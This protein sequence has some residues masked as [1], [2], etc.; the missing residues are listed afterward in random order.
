MVRTLGKPLL[1]C[2]NKLDSQDQ[3]TVLQSF[4]QRY[5]QQ[6][7]CTPP[8]IVIL[9][10]VPREI[11]PETS[12]NDG[13][14]DKTIA[15]AEAT[16]G[17]LYTAVQHALDAVDRQTQTSATHQ[18]IDTHWDLWLEPVHQ[19]MTAA[20]QWHEIVAQ[21][22]NDAEQLY[23]SRYLDNPQKYDTFN[24]A[25]AELLTLLEIPGVAK[26]LVRTRQ[27]V[28][29][30]AR[31][32]FG[33]G[34]AALQRDEHQ[35]IPDQEL[36]VLDLAFEQA[37]IHLQSE[38]FEQQQQIDEQLHWWQ[39]MHT[40]FQHN[41]LELTTQF[42]NAAVECQ[43]E[44]APRIE[45]AAKKLYGQLQEQPILL[46]TLRATR[47]STDAAAVVLAVKSGGLAPADLIIA[48]A[49]LS[50]TTLLTESVLGRFMDKIK[51]DLKREQSAHVS[52]HLLAGVL[53][54]RLLELAE[55]LDDEH[56]LLL[57]PEEKPS[58]S[59]VA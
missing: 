8:D 39:A 50:I 31:K 28:T 20:T 37:L 36:D 38:M 17:R 16:R 41:K 15:I 29:W 40:C 58:Q 14:D 6:F 44:F 52:K 45:E 49:M 46:N 30:P 34:R 32:L 43:S 18:F 27:V 26:T 5:Q 56:L 33:F 42:S 7:D 54:K 1:V 57:K 25:L 22:I 55:E 51:A 2:I 12:S 13:A 3:D 23:I 35:T 19:E 9:P 53:K 47:V 24:R 10:F 21:T 59:S 11:Q 48:P 4:E